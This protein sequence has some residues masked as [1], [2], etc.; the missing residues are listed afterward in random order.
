MSGLSDL[1]KFKVFS[2]T[3]SDDTVLSA[4]ASS[5]AAAGTHTVEVVRA[6]EQHKMFSS[7]S[8]AATDTLAT[9]TTITLTVGST[10]F[11]VDISGKTLSQAATAINEASNNSGVTATVSNVNGGYKLLL[12]SQKT[13]SSNA[14]GV[15]YSGADPFSFTTI[16]QDRNNSGAFTSADLDAVMILDGSASLTAT[17]S[18]NTVTDLIGGVTLTLKKPGTV[19]VGTDRDTASIAKSA[20]TFVDAFNS[21][22]S[23]IKT[24]RNG[25]LSSDS[26]LLSLEARVMGVL[27]TPPTG[28]TGAY[29]FLS[30]VGVAIQKDGT[31]SLDNSALTSALNSDFSGVANLFANNDQGYAYRMQNVAKD[32]LASNG[33]VDSRTTG[34]KASINTLKDQEDQVS[35]RLKLIE[36][37]YRAQFSALDTMLGSMNTTTN[38]LT[39]QLANLPG[40]R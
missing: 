19:T 8:F 16:N 12:T 22:R 9:N 32:L 3:S 4:S 38:F 39:S 34:L 23:T 13:G 14:L 35:N 26:N 17:S 5:T 36:T 7:S 10:P 28:L 18:S 24:L 30:Q 37:R 25:S 33:L 31:M 20:Q 2:A 11:S 15:S 40:Y 27:N 29:S 1:T 21:L 6:A